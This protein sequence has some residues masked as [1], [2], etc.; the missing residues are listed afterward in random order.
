M[1]NEL[2][3]KLEHKIENAI[4][5]IELLK[6][7][8][9]ELE[10]KNSKLANENSSLKNKQATWEKNLNSMLDKL[11]NVSV[12]DQPTTTGKKIYTEAYE[13]DAVL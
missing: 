6:L 4:E 11:S 10:E 7:Q 8:I 3:Q 1:S 13:E 5:S 9:E 12:L 2:L